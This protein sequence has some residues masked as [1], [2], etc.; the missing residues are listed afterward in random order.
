MAGE[1][2]AR[3]LANR[4]RCTGTARTSPVRSRVNDSPWAAR[5]RPASGSGGG[6]PP[7]RAIRATMVVEQAGLL[8]G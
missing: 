4:S 3:Q 5:K 1:V 2:I 7:A 8:Q 6:Y